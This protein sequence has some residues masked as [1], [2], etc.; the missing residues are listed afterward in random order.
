MEVGAWKVLQH[1]TGGTVII[2]VI[3]YPTDENYFAC[4]VRKAGQPKTP[5]LI[6]LNNKLKLS[7]YDNI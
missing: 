3:V 4:G 7:T 6:N 1:S 5:P 2:K